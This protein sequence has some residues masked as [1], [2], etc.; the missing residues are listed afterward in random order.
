[1]K[2][3]LIL[4]CLFAI[5]IGYTFAKDNLAI[6]PFTGGQGDE[7]ETIAE[8]FSFDAR[9]NEHFNPIPRT[10]ISRAISSEQGFQ[11]NSGMTDADTIVSIGKQLGAQYVVA[12]SITSV[13]NNKLLVISIMDIKNL[14]Q[15]AGDY[16]T[17]TNI[18]EIRGKLP[19]MAA[20]IIQATRNNTFNLPKLAIV[21]IQLQGDVDQRVADTLAQLLATHIIRSEIYAVY[22]R[23]KSLEQVMSEHNTQLSGISADENIVGIGYGEN[24][25]LVLSVVARKLGASNMF[26]AVIINILT[27]AQVVGRSVDYRNI[28]DGM[29]VMETL[30]HNLTSTAE[31]AS[32]RADAERRAQDRDTSRD[33]FWRNSGL[34]VGLRGGISIPSLFD[35]PKPTRY[36][37]YYIGGDAYTDYWEPSYTTGFSLSP[38]AELKLGRFFSFQAEMQ[39]NL[40]PILFEY[41]DNKAFKVTY[42]YIGVPLLAKINLSTGS[43]VFAPF[44]GI[45][46]NFPFGVTMETYSYEWKWLKEEGITPKVSIPPSIIFGLDAGYKIGRVLLFVD[47]RYMHGLGKSEVDSQLNRTGTD[48]YANPRSTSFTMGN[49]DISLGAKYIIPFRK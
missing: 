17:Y 43:F 47:A 42:M 7:G 41:S 32:Q 34:A 23:T 48:L 10:S 37:D 3:H 38:L 25:E 24:P 29:R 12:G 36:F 2:K 8:L 31:Q 39:F 40:S 4:V 13:G 22:P 27:G 45:S 1:M 21:P 19:N 9:L 30:A 35:I 46:L 18:E 14:Q 49:L 6:L 26:N 11:M 33:L 44:T 20:N 28:D 16:Q 15:I 5:I